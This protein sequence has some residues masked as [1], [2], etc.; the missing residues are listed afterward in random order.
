MVLSPV[1]ILSPH[2]RAE[3]FGDHLLQ[4]HCFGARHGFEMRTIPV[5]VNMGMLDSFL[6]PPKSFYGKG[7]KQ[8]LAYDTPLYFST[9]FLTWPI[10]S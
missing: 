5:G 8:W 4:S 2:D 6:T 10:F 9:T 1:V 3:L 7:L